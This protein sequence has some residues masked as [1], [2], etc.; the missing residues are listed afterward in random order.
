MKKNQ[1]KEIPQKQETPP[2]KA[3]SFG[4]VLFL[5]V[6]LGLGLWTVLSKERDFSAVERRPLAKRPVFSLSKVGEGI[7]QADYEAYLSDQFP[8]RS[9]ALALKAEFQKAIGKF[10][11]SRVYFAKDDSLI[12]KRTQLDW[13]K[14]DRNLLDMDAFSE[15]F[16][17]QKPEARITYLIAP[18]QA[19]VYPNRLPYRAVEADQAEG[20]AALRSKHQRDDL[21]YPDL[22]EGLRGSNQQDLYFKTDHHWTQKGALEAYK[23]YKMALGEKESLNRDLEIFGQAQVLS[24]DFHG[25]TYQKAPAR[26]IPGD[27]LDAFTWPDLDQV[28]VYDGQGNQLD[29]GLYKKEAL[30]STDAYEY[31][32]GPNRDL[33]QIKTANE[34]VDRGTLLLVKDSYANAFVPFLTMDYRQIIVLDLRYVKEA[35]D[36][37]LDRYEPDDLI[38]LYNIGTFSEENAT[39]KLLD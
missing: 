15:Q 36:D 23:I 13:Q 28:Q 38:F 3:A 25:T 14:L 22:L 10:D 18:T 29:Q 4:A 26:T 11:N 16:L 33:L 2:A 27:K 21:L 8:L 7:Y 39:Y 19:G 20:M 34:N 1:S 9:Q 5:L 37:I 17:K 30:T 12:E 24:Q 31:F 6:L 32:L 35:L